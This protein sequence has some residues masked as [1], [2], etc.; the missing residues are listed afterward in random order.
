MFIEYVR[1]ALLGQIS[2]INKLKCIKS[3]ISYKSMMTNGTS[4]RMMTLVNAEI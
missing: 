1:W 4:D 3:W 2:A